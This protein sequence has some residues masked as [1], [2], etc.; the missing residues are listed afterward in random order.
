[1]GGYIPF[2][3]A[4]P[5]PGTLAAGWNFDPMLLVLLAAV[6]W[7]LAAWARHAPP[8]REKT[9]QLAA[10]GGWSLLVLGLVSPL[11]N[12]TVALFSARQVQHLVLLILAAPLLACV[13]RNPGTDPTLRLGIGTA[14]FTA[15]W[16][17]W[18]LPRAYDATLQG[19]LAYWAMHLTMIGSA[20][21]FWRAL[22]QAW[23][24]APHLA[25]LA[26]LVT[27]IQMGLLG[28]LLTLASSMLYESHLV[29]TWPW[30]LM[31]LEDQQ[32]GGLVMWVVGSGLFFVIALSGLG[33]W[34]VV[35]ERAELESRGPS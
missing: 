9:T 6:G 25:A 17:I 21:L 35:A 32:L 22:F 10:I 16:W 27:N 18:H 29:T 14:A 7:Y 20:V 31:P 1:M 2:C 26:A 4:P 34:L 15:S 24:V 12:L 33:R 30:G 13:V 23:R 19:D 5:V 3:G 8:E 28:A 11:C